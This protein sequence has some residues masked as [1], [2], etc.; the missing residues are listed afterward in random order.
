MSAG[1]LDDN[2]VL[3]DISLLIADAATDHRTIQVLREARAI[4]GRYPKTEMTEEQV[5]LAIIHLAA[6]GGVQ[7]N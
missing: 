4:F 1:S 5:A 6:K 3:T 7:A 2:L